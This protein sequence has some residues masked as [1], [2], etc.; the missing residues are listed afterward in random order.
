MPLHGSC[1]TRDVSL[2]TRALP[3]PSVHNGGKWWGGG[4]RDNP[5]TLLPDGV[6]FLSQN[7]H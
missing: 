7:V 4:L 6:L 5:F 2:V 3:L 1:K